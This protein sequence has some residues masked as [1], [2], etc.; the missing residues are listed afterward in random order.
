MIFVGFAI[1]S[2]FING[3]FKRKKEKAKKAKNIS[4]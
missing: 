3:I 4:Y 1:L 2:D